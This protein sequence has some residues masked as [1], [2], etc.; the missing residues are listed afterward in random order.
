MRIN[1]LYRN[2]YP[3]LICPGYPC[4]HSHRII[5][6]QIRKST[7]LKLLSG[8]A[9][10]IITINMEYVEHRHAICNLR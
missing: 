5:W 4:K 10:G 6:Q 7:V 1:D 8:T 3:N 9:T 2:F